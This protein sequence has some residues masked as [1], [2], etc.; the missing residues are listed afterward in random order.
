MPLL[1]NS[2]PGVAGGIHVG[3]SGFC[4]RKDLRHLNIIEP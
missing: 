3:H 2:A 1:K 4:S